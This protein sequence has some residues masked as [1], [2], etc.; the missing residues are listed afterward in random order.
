MSEETKPCP[1][2]GGFG[3]IYH[4]DAFVYYVECDECD[5]SSQVCCSEEE[6]VFV[7]NR[8]V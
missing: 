5:S 6:A 7:W 2:C 1:F 4:P 3:R 8:R